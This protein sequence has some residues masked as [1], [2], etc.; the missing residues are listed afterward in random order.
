MV[1]FQCL[2]CGHCCLEAGPVLNIEQEDIDRWVNEERKDIL[3]K[4]YQTRYVCDH[5]YDEFLVS[6]GKRCPTCN[7]VCKKGIYYWLDMRQPTGFLA[8]MM[9]NPRCPFLRKVRKKAEYICRIHETKPRDCREFPDLETDRVTKN[10]QECIEWDCRGYREWTNRNKTD[11][12][13]K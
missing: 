11:K 1:K 5:C 2:R 4:L 10:E 8:Q 6:A 3:D 13:K 12:S 7:R 9:A